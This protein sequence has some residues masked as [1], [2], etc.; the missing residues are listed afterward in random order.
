MRFI[1]IGA[2]LLVT[3]PA[4]ADNDECVA[5]L[6]HGIY[7]TYRSQQNG[8]STSTVYNQIC[9]NYQL[10]ENHALKV[11]VNGQYGLFS[12]GG[13]FSDDAVKSI[14]QAMCGSNYSN[15]QASQQID[16]FSQVISP[17][18]ADA[19]K[20]CVR[21]HQKGLIV[22]TLFD[23]NDPNT[24]TIGVTYVPNG[25]AGN[26][27]FSSYTIAVDLAVPDKYKAFCNG[28]LEEK[29]KK[30]AALEP[31]V[32]FAMVCTRPEVPDPK[33]A[34]F[35][36]GI[37]LLAAAAHIQV[38]TDVDQIDLVFPKIPVEPDFVTK[39]DSFSGG[40]RLNFTLNGAGDQCPAGEY[41][42]NATYFGEKNG[43]ITGYFPSVGTG[44]PCI[45]S[46]AFTAKTGV[47]NVSERTITLAAGQ[48]TYDVNGILSDFNGVVGYMVLDPF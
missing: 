45:P 2:C 25:V 14:G 44:V 33:D 48:L 1:I 23:E 46:G 43:R 6:R 17:A 4:L 7:D 15:D 16:N 13:S 21:L 47:W 20:A 11:D 36:G 35:S 41:W 26:N 27:V 37:K 31:N 30:K 5:L 29:L 40:I 22:D 38:G 8:A 24:A 19:F 12:G 32:H 3:V 10:Y 9:T 34:F 39:L 18:G 28:G 42:R